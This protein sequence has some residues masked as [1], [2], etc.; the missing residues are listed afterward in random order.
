[1]KNVDDGNIEAVTRFMFLIAVG[2]IMLI[3][4]VSVIF[5][6]MLLPFF[7]EHIVA[8]KLDSIW[9]LEWADNATN[10]SLY[11]MHDYNKT[12]QAKRLQEARDR[13]DEVM[14]YVQNVT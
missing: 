7:Q 13:R 4:L 1:L 12:R 11:L 3:M 2:V 5:Y 9:Q 14:R 8:V 6:K 10:E